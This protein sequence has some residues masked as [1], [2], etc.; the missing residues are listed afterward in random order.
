MLF[1]A[2]LLLQAS[3]ALNSHS[4]SRAW[5]KHHELKSVF[6][7]V[8]LERAHS[9]FFQKNTTLSCF[10]RTVSY[11]DRGV[12][13]ASPV[14]AWGPAVRPAR[15]APAEPG[16]VPTGISSAGLPAGSWSRWSGACAPSWA[17]RWPSEPPCLVPLSLRAE[18]V[19]RH[20]IFLRGL[21]VRKSSCSLRL[22]NV[23]HVR[24]FH[25]SLLLV[26]S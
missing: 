26:W 4:A 24:L 21:L 16:T 1:A 3:T 11:F 8:I 9:N 20:V 22:E 25:T 14:S 12:D 6:A 13:L 2:P 17:S 23:T 18:R 5:S 19:K 7:P 15:P 10:Y